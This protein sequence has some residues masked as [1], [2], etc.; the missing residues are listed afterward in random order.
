[1]FVERLWRS[2]KC[3]EV[4][5]KTYDSVGAARQSLVRHFDFSNTQR[6]YPSHG[7]PTPDSI[8]QSD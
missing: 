4:Y 6:L 7:V 1:V 3:E 8:P 5:F 2:V